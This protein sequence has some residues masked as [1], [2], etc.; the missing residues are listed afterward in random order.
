MI[1]LVSLNR[2]ARP[3][4][5]DAIDRP[6]IVPLL[7]QRP[8]HLHRYV[9]RSSIAEAEDR[10]VVNIVAVIGII[11][12]R[13]IPP[14]V[15]PIPITATVTDEA[16][17]AVPPPIAV[18]TLPPIPALRRTIR[19]LIPTAFVMFPRLFVPL[20]IIARDNVGLFLPFIGFVGLN[21]LGVLLVVIGVR[22]DVR[23]SLRVLVIA[24][25]GNLLIAARLR[26]DML[27]T[28][29]RA[30]LR[31]STRLRADAPIACLRP[32]FLW[33]GCRLR[34]GLSLFLFLLF[35]LIVGL[36]GLDRGQAHQ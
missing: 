24:V 32:A 21:N 36:R 12:I 16:V 5:Q 27:L 25:G 7:R 6:I 17:I 23:L 3:W 35:L 33:R 34:R 10:T 18:V 29:L 8:L 26:G 31:L 4:T 11:S 30:H 14:A 20:R 1:D 19:P 15:V 9:A 13:G 28:G 22:R 2:A